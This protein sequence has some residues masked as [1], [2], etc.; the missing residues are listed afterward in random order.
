[1]KSFS[2][3]W[4]ISEI[5][6]IFMFMRFRSLLVHFFSILSPSSSF[7]SLE[8]YLVASWCFSAFGLDVL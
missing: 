3:N 7:F 6:A 2:V 4:I 8:Y 5:S 1:M